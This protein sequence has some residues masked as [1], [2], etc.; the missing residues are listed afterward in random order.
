M[1]RVQIYVDDDIHKEI[2]RIKA[3]ERRGSLSNTYTA[4]L[5]EALEARRDREKRQQRKAS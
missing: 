3:E 1:T 2:E 5:G 4:L